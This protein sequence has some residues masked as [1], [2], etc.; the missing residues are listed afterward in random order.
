MQHIQWARSNAGKL[1]KIRL[2]ASGMQRKGRLLPP[3]TLYM[4][5]CSSA[6]PSFD[7]CCS[8]REHIAAPHVSHPSHLRWRR[9]FSS[10]SATPTP[11]RLVVTKT[12]FAPS[13]LTQ[14]MLGL[15]SAFFGQSKTDIQV[16]MKVIAACINLAIPL[17]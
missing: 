3:L 5:N 13:H 9:L 7:N 6:F 12:L 10:S 4:S 11:N 1:S 16:T 2:Q 14:S 8:R 17:L 15:S